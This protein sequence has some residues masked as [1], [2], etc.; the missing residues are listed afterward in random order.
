V[1]TVAGYYRYFDFCKADF[2]QEKNGRA[3]GFSLDIYKRKHEVL[4]ELLN[5]RR[6]DPSRVVYI[7]DSE[8]DEGCFQIVGY[9]VVAFLA[10]DLLKEKYASE[11]YAFIPR[12]EDDLVA[13]LRSI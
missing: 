10:P 8:D 7:G 9:P 6:L 1:L 4:A 11:Y 2:L 3:V 5:E 13:Y 12:D